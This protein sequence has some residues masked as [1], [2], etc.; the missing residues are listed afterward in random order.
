[1]ARTVLGNASAVTVPRQLT[2]SDDP[3]SVRIFLW[4][5]RKELSPIGSR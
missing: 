2:P 5:D 1:M 4:R 3:G